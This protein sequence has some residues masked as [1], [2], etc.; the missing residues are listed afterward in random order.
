MSEIDKDK[1]RE[2]HG[3]MQGR[4]DRAIM[5]DSKRHI[6]I[7]PCSRLLVATE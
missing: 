7:V 4:E 2:P 5:E 3:K 1:V 6:E